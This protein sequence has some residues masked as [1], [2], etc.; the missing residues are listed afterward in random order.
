MGCSSLNILEPISNTFCSAQG[1]PFSI[2]GGS[3]IGEGSL[4]DWQAWYKVPLP[5][6]RGRGAG[7]HGAYR[8]T[9]VLPGH[10]R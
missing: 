3:V 9:A 6:A 8:F 1:L 5:T 2:L 7:G 10:T 4:V